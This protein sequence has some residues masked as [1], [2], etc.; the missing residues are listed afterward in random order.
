MLRFAFWYLLLLGLG[1]SACQSEP[2]SVKEHLAG[3][4]LWE[5]VTTQVWIERDTTF[6]YISPFPLLYNDTSYYDFDLLLKPL[7]RIQGTRNTHL[8]IRGGYP[9]NPIIPIDPRDS[10]RFE[11]FS[12]LHGQYF[13]PF[14][15]CQPNNTFS[16]T[17]KDA[18]E[19]RQVIPY[20]KI[21]YLS[22]DEVV[23]VLDTVGQYWQ[24]E[25]EQYHYELLFV[26]AEIPYLFLFRFNKLDSSW[27]TSRHRYH[28]GRVGIINEVPFL[29][30]P[31]IAINGSTVDFSYLLGL[32]TTKGKLLLSLRTPTGATPLT[33]TATSFSRHPVQS[34]FDQIQAVWDSLGTPYTSREVD[35]VKRT[36]D[37]SYSSFREIFYLTP[38]KQFLLHIS[39]DSLRSSSATHYA[40][41][42][43]DFYMGQKE[44]LFL[45]D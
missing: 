20:R 8:N 13:Q 9:L 41:S 15:R 28:D 3:E 42:S 40:L 31:F 35:P 23:H 34:T 11:P 24:G 12:L 1:F 32:G 2:C 36:S 19:Q 27:T 45:L 38:S 16:L 29:V 22:A 14:F 30:L 5:P 21:D 33:L 17:Y 43:R 7:L 10:I 37:F 44:K 25:Q 18:Q 4:Y 39:M 26:D 6:T